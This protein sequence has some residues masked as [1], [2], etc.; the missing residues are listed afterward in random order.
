MFHAA[1]FFKDM[2]TNDPLTAISVAL[3]AGRFQHAEALCRDALRNQ[4]QDER[5]LAS[6]GITLQ[7]QQRLPEA[8]AVLEE[9]TRLFP[10]NSVHWSNYGVV[11]AAMGH[12]ESAEKAYQLAIHADSS[13]IVPKVRLGMLL[14]DRKDYL[15]ARE[16]MLDAVELAPDSPWA[17]IH[18]AHACHLAQDLDG[19]GDLLR[20]WRH[21]TPLRDDPLQ[22]ELAMVLAQHGAVPDAID[23]L[24]DLLPRQP[25]LVQAR[26]LLAN[27]YE[28]SNRLAEALALVDS[29]AGTVGVTD[30]QRSEAQHLRA[31][32]ALRQGNPR[33]VA[34]I[35]EECGPFGAGDYGHYFQLATAY[36]KLGDVAAAMQALA[37]AH[38]IEAIERQ[39]DSPEHFTPETPALAVNTPRV[40]AEQYHRWPKLL[41]PEAEYS[42]VFVVGFPR[43]GTTLLEQMLDAHPGLQSMDENPFFGRLSDFLRSHDP[44]ILDDLSVLRQYDCDELRKRYYNM[45]ANRV[46]LKEGVRLVDKNPLNMRWLPFIYRLFP[47]AKFI[48]AVRHPCDVL[49]SCYM[50]TFRSAILAAACTN[51]ER[52]AHAYVET[53]SHWLEDLELFRPTV[54]ES[55][56]E[57]MV[58]DFAGH[59]ERIA[60]FLDLGDASPM[61][62]FDR[63]AR[64]KG[65]IGTP[66]YSQVI[67]PVN[68]RAVGRWH[69]Y[70]EYF[71][72]VLPILE[73]MLRH[74]GYDVSST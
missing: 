10:Q 14:L 16:L 32:L 40:S 38:R 57:T 3:D 22:M 33:E 17:R 72:P 67:E 56:Y 1:L 36:D 34:R 19:A 28:R 5:L 6:L 65:F 41:A 24:E 35:L 42:P 20:P 55:R 48:L 46:T 73:P 50:Q 29:V 59:A 8:L 15:A 44:R 74:W 61:L 49:L 27:V 12:P 25:Q 51:L 52:L 26:L 30:A 47:E 13:N 70:R 53:M 11:I 64:S 63:H 4:P 69:K 18:A 21:W 60:S 54:M 23:V 31:T 9:L 45:V 43:S 58:D 39:F 2:T 71:E 37:E 62:A 66:S 7:W 68:R